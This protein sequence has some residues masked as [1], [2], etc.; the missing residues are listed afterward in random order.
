M[1]IFCFLM[2]KLMNIF[3]K[4][5]AAVLIICTLFSGGCSHNQTKAVN[6][7]EKG[8]PL[9]INN[10]DGYAG[11]GRVVQQV[12]N[13]APQRILAVSASV[14]DNLIFLGLQDK[15]IAV[16]ADGGG[17]YEPYEK[18]YGKLHIL[19]KNYAYPSK[20]TVLSQKPDLIIGWGSLFGDEA[21]GSVAYWHDKGIHTYVMS[22]TVPI[23]AS[24]PRKVEN[25][26][27]DL[28][29][30]SRIFAVESETKDKI[31]GLESRLDKIKQQTHDLP[32]EARPTVVTIQYMY[33]NE[34]LERSYSD[35]TADIIWQAGGKSLDVGLGSRQSI[36]YL[37]EKNPDIIILV[38]M[39]G[40]SVKASI[41]QLKSNNILKNVTAVKNNN[42][43][44][45][46]HRAFYCGSFHTIEAVEQLHA[47]IVKK[48]Q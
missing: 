44:V 22:N 9:T 34:Y 11:Q 21:L 6:D 40:K 5:I 10:Y 19:T 16:A 15:I 1:L 14:I 25:F 27:T 7:T 20:E 41:E 4:K 48:Q 29:N 47:F 32:E 45:I 38:D 23:E 30:I 43:F 36:E 13:Q 26:I 39:Q 8:Y 46:E 3:M 35:L 18:E 17:R 12:F 33:G 28:K 37:V 24:G 42:F 31:A 2:V